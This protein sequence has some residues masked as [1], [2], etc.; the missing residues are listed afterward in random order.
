MASWETMTGTA[1]LP[2]LIFSSATS[3]RREST[4]GLLHVPAPRPAGSTAGMEFLDGGSPGVTGYQDAIKQQAATIDR[5]GC[6][7]GAANIA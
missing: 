5:G 3:Y 6:A 7:P 4:R 1:Y 2:P